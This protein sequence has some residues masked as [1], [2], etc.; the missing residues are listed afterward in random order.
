MLNI[1]KREFWFIVG[2]QHLYGEETLNQVRKHAKKI[3]SGLNK[4]AELPYPL[5][6]KEV[7]TTADEIT[8]L[9]KEVNY[10]DQVAGGITWMHTFSPATMWIQ[11]TKLWQKPQLQLAV[12]FDKEGTWERTKMDKK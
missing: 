9:M 2:S 8:S 12:Q 3:L 6:F 4:H 10:Q 11:G 1:K 7:V 5:I